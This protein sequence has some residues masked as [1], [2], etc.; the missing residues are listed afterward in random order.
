MDE[1]A[2][3]EEQEALARRDQQMM[4]L[5]ELEAQRQAQEGGEAGD[6][7]GEGDRDLDDDIPEAE[8][9]TEDVTFN[10]ESLLEGSIVQ[11]D[12]DAENEAQDDDVDVEQMLEMEE[13]EIDGVLQDERDLDDD[14]PEAGSYEH[15][16]TELEDDTNEIED[17]FAGHAGGG[18]RLNM[19]QQARRSFTSAE[20]SS[21]LGGSS[22][23]ES[24]PAAGRGRGRDETRG[25]TFRDRLMN[26]RAGQ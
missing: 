26:R 19:E 8:G 23:L 5:A 6:E 12:G 1:L 21:I 13:A 24:S 16:D 22:F 18:G 9:E 20:A 2:E 11:H 7:E 15:T 10:E 25:A 17:P 3:R 4:E 14:V